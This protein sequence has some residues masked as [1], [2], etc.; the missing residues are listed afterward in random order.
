MLRVALKETYSLADSLIKGRELKVFQLDLEGTM[1]PV[2]F[3]LIAGT[4]QTS[5][6][7]LGISG[8]TNVAPRECSM[9][10]SSW[11]NLGDVCLGLDPDNL[12]VAV[13]FGRLRP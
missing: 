1:G 3:Y 13:E 10:K 7:Q 8:S 9:L 4:L 5:S 2:F 11:R 6:P 12:K